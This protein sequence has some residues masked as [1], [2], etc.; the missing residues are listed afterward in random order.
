MVSQTQGGQFQSSQTRVITAFFDSR[1]D[2]N[3]AIE[4]L[5]RLGIDRTNIKIV[6]GSSQ[7]VKST[8]AQQNSR[9]GESHGFWE[10]L[11]DLFLP[12]EDRYTYAEGLSRG[13]YLVTVTATDAQYERTLDILDDEGTVNMDERAQSWRKEG[14]SGYDERFSGYGQTGAGTGSATATGA[15]ASTRS[16]IASGAASSQQRTGQTDSESIPIVEEQLQVGKR[17]VNHGRVRVRSYVVEKP[18]QE[19]VTLRDENVSVERRP[20]NRP[21]T[22]ADDPFWE[23]TIEAQGKREEAVVNKQARVTEEIELKRDVKQRTET[24]SDKVRETKVDVEDQTSL[25]N[26]RDA[27]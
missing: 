1:Q 14:W 10:S 23:R 7:G 16:G 27:G 12:D 26:K 6:E 8:S 20:V 21:L 11:A 18:V 9:G 24:V 22:G 15:A 5:T 25:R 2:A 13:G 19:Q 4:R 3:E 17:E